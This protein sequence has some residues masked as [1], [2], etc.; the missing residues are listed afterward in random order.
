MQQLSP[1]DRVGS[2]VLDLFAFVGALAMFGGRAVVQAARPP[3]E[4]R[5][6]LKHASRA[7]PAIWCGIT[8]R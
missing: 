2:G 3:Y 1:V 4:P 5:E 8:E 6:I 7:L